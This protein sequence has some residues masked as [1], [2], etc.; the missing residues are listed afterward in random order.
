ML[1]TKSA[2]S[3]A[4]MKSTLAVFFVEFH[5]EVTCNSVGPGV[6]LPDRIVTCTNANVYDHCVRMLL[7]MKWFVRMPC[8][9]LHFNIYMLERFLYVEWAAKPLEKIQGS[10]SLQWVD[11]YSCL[12]L[13]AWHGSKKRCLGVATAPLGA[14]NQSTNILCNAPHMFEDSQHIASWNFASHPWHRCV[15]ETPQES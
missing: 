11:R 1:V 15:S 14:I 10:S 9:Y 13:L 7:G 2:V 8:W 5:W 6:L 12:M 3:N 4:R